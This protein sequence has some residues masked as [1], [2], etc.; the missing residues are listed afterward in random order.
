[1]TKMVIHQIILSLTEYEWYSEYYLGY[2]ELDC[3]NHD[4]TIYPGAP[5]LCDGLDNDCDGSIDED[6]VMLTY[7]R[8]ADGDTFGDPDVTTSSCS[9]PAGFVTNASDCDDT[10]S[11]VKPGAVEIPD[12]GLDNDCVG[13]DQVSDVDLSDVDGDGYTTATD[14]DDTDVN[15]NPLGVEICGDGVDQ[16]CDGVDTS[17]GSADADGD[18]YLVGT[19]CDDTNATVSPSGTEICGDGIDQDCYGSD[20]SCPL[21][22]A[23]AVC[24]NS[25]VETG[26]TCDDGNTNVDDGC[27]STCQLEQVTADSGSTD[28]SSGDSSS[29][30]GG[31]C[32]LRQ[33]NY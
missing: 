7:Y 1:M 20:L 6:F 18:G 8:D 32:S 14:C 30:S 4:A 16:N 26:E 15:I 25:I 31:G 33:P 17:C 19:D 13:G 24:G 27:D 23:G 12:D 2:T 9:L 28:N 5:E 11:A 22:S 21:S 29:S 3:D 10:N